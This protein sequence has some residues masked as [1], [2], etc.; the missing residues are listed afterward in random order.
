MPGRSLQLWFLL[1]L[2]LPLSEVSAAKP[3]FIN[4]MVVDTG[5]VPADTNSQGIGPGRGLG[6]QTNYL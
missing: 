3:T 5:V 4:A 1:L 6:G 2:F